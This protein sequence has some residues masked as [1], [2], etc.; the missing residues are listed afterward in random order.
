MRD[1]KNKLMLRKLI[2]V[3][4]VTY[5][6]ITFYFS[7]FS[8]KPRLYELSLKNTEMMDLQIKLKVMF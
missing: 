8:F 5:R 7:I 6:G 4:K 1:N 2:Y 3:D